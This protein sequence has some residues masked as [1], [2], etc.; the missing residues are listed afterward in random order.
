MSIIRVSEEE[1][2]RQLLGGSFPRLSG[3][4]GRRGLSLSSLEPDD[5]ITSTPRAMAISSPKGRIYAAQWPDLPVKPLGFARAR[6]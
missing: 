2:A 5:C 1:V 3:A 6:A 4:G